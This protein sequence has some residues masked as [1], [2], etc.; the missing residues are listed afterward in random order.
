MLSHRVR[1]L[2]RQLNSEIG[3]HTTCAQFD[4]VGVENRKF[5][6]RMPVEMRWGKHSTS[7]TLITTRLNLLLLPHRRPITP[8][9][10]IGNKQTSSIAIF[11]AFASAPILFGPESG[12][13]ARL[14]HEQPAAKAIGGPRHRQQP[15]RS[16]PCLV[17]VA[18]F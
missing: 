13:F 14:H 1:W 11:L 15:Q 10:P 8:P 5:V 2:C 12:D 6:V 7:P 4:C 3:L 17:R 9:P 16:P 18:V